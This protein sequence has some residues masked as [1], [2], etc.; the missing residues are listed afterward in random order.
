MA[1]N[2]LLKLQAMGQS[3]WLDFIDRQL[4]ESGDLDRLID[5]DGV[6]GMT[7]NP[8]IFE[9]S[10][11]GSRVYAQAIGDL[12]RQGFTDLEIYER[13]TV[14][15]VQAAADRFHR[16]YERTQGIDG[17]VSLEV[18][19]HL[20]RDTRGTLTEARRLWRAL[21]RPNVLIKVPATAEGV[22]AIR[23]LISEGVNVNVTLLFGLER[24]RQVALAMIDGLHDRLASGLPIGGIASVASFFLSRIDVLLDPQLAQRA[25]V[26]G[27]RAAEAARLKGG[28]AIASAKR[29]YQIYRELFHGEEFDELRRSGG[30]PQ[31]LLWASTSTKDPDYS[32]VKYVEALIGPETV[33]TIPMETLEAYRDHGNPSPRLG[34]DLEAAR[35]DLDALSSLGIDLAAATRQLEEEGVEKFNRPYD[36]LLKTIQETISN[37]PASNSL[38]DS[39]GS[40]APV[41]AEELRALQAQSFGQRLWSKDASLWKADPAQQDVIRNALGWLNVA[42]SMR[43]S[44]SELMEFAAEIRQDG[45]RHVV[46]MGMGGSSL[47]PMVFARTFTGASGGLPLSILDT[48]DPAAIRKLESELPLE[49]TL[50]IVAS[51]SGTTSE[52]LAFEEFFYQRLHAIKGEAAASNFVVISDPGTPM[53]ERARR[54]GYRRVFLNFKDIGGRYSALS[55]F[56]LVPAVLA[57]V[58]VAALLERALSMAA[59]CAA[60]H[61]APENPGLQLGAILGELGLRRR[62]KVTLF[63]S[64]G[65]ET[66]GMWLEQLLAESTGKEGTGLLP[67]AAEAL[68]EPARRYGDDRLFV[69]LVLEGEK[70]PGE[71][72]AHLEKAGHPVVRLQLKDRLD[73]GAE[74]LRWE[75]A[76]ATAGALLGI[77]AFDQPN[78][79]ESKD[80]TR[81]LL[82]AF[83]ARGH[84]EQEQPSCRDALLEVTAYEPSADPSQALRRFFSAVRPGSYIAL[85]AYLPEEP[86]I[87]TALQALRIKLRDA[88]RTATTLGF[89]PRFLHS[90]GQYHK[91]GPANGLFVQFT[92]DP[93]VEAPIPGKPYGFGVLWQAQALGDL[94][95]LR[96]H[97]RP[98]IRV[99]LTGDILDGLNHV[100]SLL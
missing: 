33:N 6:L 67:V 39:L 17:F 61:P 87:Q 28:I 43:S 80:N 64:P 20:A 40:Y 57:G 99:H 92:A 29:A 19:P 97:G 74:F 24:Y 69:S 95:A 30:L 12:A 83:E 44:I 46:H 26:P 86:A 3:I 54:R 36:K 7:S 90:T 21:D 23:T 34:H 50:F 81:R 77:N 32:D 91:G 85:M 71:A 98:V 84:L 25:G 94:Q 5:D 96:Q 48:T 70:L 73:L 22:P 52:A 18:S 72:L 76:T 31:R 27:P 55:Y 51:K 15:D 89:G 75:I 35:K 11:V 88:H 78:V 49:H 16:V 60:L 9:K 4:I 79:Q 13:L 53:V 1:E 37:P 65:I 2:P 14:A 42:E 41:V 100:A 58:D 59:A 68:G 82:D 56:G 47:A 10:I 93:G 8:A 62:D 63:T 66:F 45:F 38:T